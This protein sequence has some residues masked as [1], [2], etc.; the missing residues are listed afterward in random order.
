MSATTWE[1]IFD[2]IVLGGAFV[3]CLIIVVA[4]DFVSGRVG[5]WITKKELQ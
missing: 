1:D 4:M 5:K 2:F 3:I